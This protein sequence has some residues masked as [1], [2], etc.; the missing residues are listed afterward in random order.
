MDNKEIPTENTGSV[1]A[2]TSNVPVQV[3]G[4]A[5]LDTPKQSTTTKSKRKASVKDYLVSS[6]STRK[7]FS[8]TNRARE[9]SLMLSRR[10]FT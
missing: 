5:I 4:T 6:W 3:T 1:D 9:F 2:K 8:L 10:T 7:K